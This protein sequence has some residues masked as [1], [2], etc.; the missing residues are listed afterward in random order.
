MKKKIKINLILQLYASQSVLIV[1]IV[2]GLSTNNQAYQI[3]FP[4]ICKPCSLSAH[5]QNTVHCV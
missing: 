3:F 1:K 4:R 5:V 2:Y